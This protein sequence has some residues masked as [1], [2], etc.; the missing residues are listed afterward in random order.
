M[1]RVAQISHPDDNCPRR[2]LLAWM[3]LIVQPQPKAFT[4]SKDN[5]MPRPTLQGRLYTRGSGTRED[6][7]LLD[8]N[9]TE[10]A[11]ACSLN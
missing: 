3:A 5:S 6:A 9:M 11:D 4:L 2:K 8:D 1:H 10:R 7:L